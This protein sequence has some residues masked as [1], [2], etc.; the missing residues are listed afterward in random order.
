[1]VRRERGFYRE[2]SVLEAI[3]ATYEGGAPDAP[4]GP[5]VRALGRDA[6]GAFSR[7]TYEGPLPAPA[8]VTP[9]PR[10][11]HPPPPGQRAARARG[12]PPRRPA[13]SRVDCSH[14]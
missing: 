8:R 1:A 6:E 2:H 13:L 7:H 12:G 4:R 5:R 10:P 3:H 14:L 11:A 9:D